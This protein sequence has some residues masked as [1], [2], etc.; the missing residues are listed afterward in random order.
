[1]NSALPARKEAAGGPSAGSQPSQST[2]Q[3]TPPMGRR[4]GPGRTC[5]PGPRRPVIRKPSPGARSGSRTV[6]GSASGSG[7]GAIQGPVRPPISR[8]R[9][10]FFLDTDGQARRPP[11]NSDAGPPNAVRKAGEEHH[12]FNRP[13]RC[14]RR[15]PLPGSATPPRAAAA[16]ARAD[17]RRPTGGQAAGCRDRGRAPRKSR[18][19][20][21]R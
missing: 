13:D 3:A 15:S 12:R 8:T 17:R 5:V 9:D 16:R 7:S 4:W 14:G 10:S 19:S 18:Q 6:S 11:H 20:G 21:L 1:M 2:T